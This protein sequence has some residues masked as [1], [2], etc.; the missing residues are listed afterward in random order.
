MSLGNLVHCPQPGTD[1]RSI[2]T[3]VTAAAVVVSV[4]AIVAAASTATAAAAAARLHPETSWSPDTRQH[5]HCCRSPGVYPPQR[6]RCV[7]SGRMV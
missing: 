3:D 2:W 5:R 6:N 4:V 1:Y 7:D